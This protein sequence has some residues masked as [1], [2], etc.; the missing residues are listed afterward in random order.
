MTVQATMVMVRSLLGCDD[1]LF[2]SGGFPR[3][4]MDSVEATAGRDENQEYETR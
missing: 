1:P 2:L 4:V 3:W